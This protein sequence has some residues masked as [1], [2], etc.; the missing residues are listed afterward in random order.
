MFAVD[1][2]VIIDKSPELKCGCTVVADIREPEPSNAVPEG[3]I[4]VHLA[5]NIRQCRA[6][7]TFARRNVQ[8]RGVCDVARKKD[9]DDSSQVARV[10]I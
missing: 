10:R 6:A 2:V 3:A 1:N 7:V 5:V 8:E 9:K 4:V